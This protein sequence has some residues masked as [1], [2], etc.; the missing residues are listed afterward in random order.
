M[1]D[2]RGGL[3]AYGSGFGKFAVPQ[4]Q[5]LLH[6]QQYG[7]GPQS[8]ALQGTDTNG[9][10]EINAN[11][12]TEVVGIDMAGMALR[13]LSPSLYRFS[14]ITMLYLSGNLLTRIPAGMS[15]MAALTVLD[16]SN[17]RLQSIPADI[18]DLVRLR[19]LLLYNN[20]VSSLPF[21]L[22]RLFMLQ[23]LGLAG[24]PLIEPFLSLS[25]EGANHLVTFLL[26]NGPVRPAPAERPWI[27]LPAPEDV[28]IPPTA[29]GFTIM[30]YNVLCDKYA[31]RQLYGYCP[32]WALEWG[33]RKQRI[34]QEIIGHNADI[35]CLQEVETEQ[36]QDYFYPEL[37]R[38]GYGG[39]FHPKSRARTMSDE[40]RRFVDGCAIFFRTSKFALVKDYLISL[41][42]SPPQMQSTATR[43]RICSIALCQKTTS[44][45]Q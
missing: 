31:T 39:V 33:Y 7:L 24:N 10:V 5:G 40:K 34:L 44:P 1:G 22:G 37:Q 41:T 21:E 30:C 28:N 3:V 17:N 16:L 18:G 25:Q 15:R 13:A 45:S 14:H 8:K 26:D 12:P 19:E 9:G 23:T 36:F 4:S 43:K 2:L 6:Q 27:Q 38:Q 29:E 42:N 35:V 11:K 32:T 20:L